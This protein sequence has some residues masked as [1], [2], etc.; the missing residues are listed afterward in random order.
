MGTAAGYASKDFSITKFFGSIDSHLLKSADYV[1]IDLKGAS[2]VQ[3]KAIKNYVSS[4]SKAQRK[5][6]TYVN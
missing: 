6:I 5:K 3:I 2:K 1:A 4:L